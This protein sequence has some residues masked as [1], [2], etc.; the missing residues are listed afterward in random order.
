MSTPEGY[1]RKD[2]LGDGAYVQMGGYM[3]EV[4]LTTEDGVSVQNRIV[5]SNSE[6]ANLLRWLIQSGGY[7]AE[8]IRDLA[9]E[10]CE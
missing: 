3:T 10:F 4:V 7:S 6:I 1:P 5:L 9:E 2:Y 8:K